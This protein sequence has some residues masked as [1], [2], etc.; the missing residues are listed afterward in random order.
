MLISSYNPITYYHTNINNAKNLSSLTIAGISS[1]SGAYN[2]S[3]PSSG[4][5]MRLDLGKAKFTNMPATQGGKTAPTVK[6]II[7]PETMTSMPT[8]TSYV[9][10]SSVFVPSN[11][12]GF[13]VNAFRTMKNLSAGGILF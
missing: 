7:L 11:I 6:Y 9:N 10:L 3:L 8:L 2:F 12:R 13:N 5:D 1:I 4:P